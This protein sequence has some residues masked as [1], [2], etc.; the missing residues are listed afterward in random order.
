M[1]ERLILKME[2]DG[3]EFESMGETE[4]RYI[5]RTHVPHLRTQE[6]MDNIGVGCSYPYNGVEEGAHDVGSG[7]EFS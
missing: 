5:V 4:L 2:H 1:A 3:V 6:E 7:S